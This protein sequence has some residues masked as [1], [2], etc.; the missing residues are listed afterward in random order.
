MSI[1]KKTGLIVA[2]LFVIAAVVFIWYLQDRKKQTEFVPHAIAKDS[3][4]FYWFKNSIIYNLDVK[5]FKDSDGDGIGDFKGLVQKLGY[6]D[7][8]G[9]TVIWLAPFQP[10]AGKDD[11][12]DITD[13][14][15]VDPR[16]GTTEDFKNFVQQAQKHNMRVIIDLVMNHTSDQHPWFQQARSNS[17]SP[18]HDW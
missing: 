18:F 10:S 1:K 12:Y 2:I 3:A 8:L 14:Y 13:Y 16:L 9:V 6:L 5:V 11:G 17:S 7:S 4:G 15:S